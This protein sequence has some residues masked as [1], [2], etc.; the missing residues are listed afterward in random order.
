MNRSGAVSRR[1][2][3]LGTE[4]FGLAIVNHCRLDGLGG[5]RGDAGTQLGREL[6]QCTLKATRKFLH[7]DREI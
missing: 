4:R 1:A 2:W 6:A 3:F 5:E 7:T